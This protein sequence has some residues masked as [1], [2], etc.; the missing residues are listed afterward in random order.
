MGSAALRI[1]YCDRLSG[2]L[3][4]QEILERILKKTAER[5]LVLIAHR[6]NAVGRFDRIVAFRD[7]QI[8]ADGKFEKLMKENAYFR[9][10]Y[11]AGSE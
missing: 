5:T 11:L 7:G 9:E 3:S 4:Q 8:E 1:R 6:L 10:L 2:E